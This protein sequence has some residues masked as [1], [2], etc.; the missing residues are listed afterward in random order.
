MAIG[1]NAQTSYV[2]VLGPGRIAVIDTQS[3]RVSTTISVGPP[4]T[5]PFNLAVT[6]SRVYV[7]NQGSG[8]VSVID[9]NTHKVLATVPVGNSP[10]GIAV[11]P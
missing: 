10:Y 5:D 3:H 4:G 2:A 8:N 11:K 6:P 9:P 1:P 7:A